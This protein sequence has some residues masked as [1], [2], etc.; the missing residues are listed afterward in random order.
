MMMRNTIFAFVLLVLSIGQ[1]FGVHESIHRHQKQH[2]SRQEYFKFRQ[3][4]RQHTETKGGA[5]VGHIPEHFLDHLGMES[6]L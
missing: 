5:Y 6:E 4:L 1:V 2:H 3:Q